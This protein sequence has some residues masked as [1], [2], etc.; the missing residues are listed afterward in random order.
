ME[1]QMKLLVGEGESKLE[2]DALPQVMANASPVFRAMLQPDRFN[3]GQKLSTD[4]FCIISLPDDDPPTMEILCD[5]LH[6]RTDKVPSKGMTADSLAAFAALVDKY[7]CALAIHPWPILWLADLKLSNDLL[8]NVDFMNEEELCT[9]TYISCHLGYKNLFRKC[10]SA[11]IRGA[12]DDSFRTGSFMSSCGELSEMIR[13]KIIFTTQLVTSF[14][15]SHTQML[16]KS[17]RNL[18]FARFTKYAVTW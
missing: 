18:A 15:N 2:I 1:Y 14:G 5:I 7:D 12:T 9:W 13:S 11:L 3:E 6:L 17:P 4:K 16:L 8:H 10:T